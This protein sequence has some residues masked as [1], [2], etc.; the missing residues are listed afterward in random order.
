MVGLR[1]KLWLSFI[2]LCLAVM[3][4][5]QASVL[6]NHNDNG[7]TG[8]NLNE[9]SLTTSNVGPTTFGRLFA[10]S[11]DGQIYAQ[12]LI[13][14]GLSIRGKT[15]NVVYVATMNDS[16]YAFDADD[17]TASSPLWHD[18]FTNPPNVVPVPYQDLTGA[19][20]I[21]PI[22]GILSTPVI[23]P[24]TNTIFVVT[25]SLEGDPNVDSSYVQRLHAIDLVTGAERQKS[26]VVLGASVPGTGD[27]GT[28][29]VYDGRIQNQRPGLLL[30][31]GIVY[32]ASASHG[33]N[34]SYH[35][36]VLGYDE[37]SLTLK[38]AHVTTPNGYR[39][40]IW[41]S[42][43]GLTADAN[44]YIYFMT[45]NGL[46]DADP[47]LTNGIDYGDTFEKLD[48]NNNLA[49]VDFF[50]PH[51]QGDLDSSDA[52]LGASGPMLIP[53]SHCIIGGGK[54]GLLYLVNTDDM[55]HFSS[56]GTDNVQQE[57][58]G[59]AG[60]LHGTTA[61]WNGP[62]GPTLYVWGEGDACYAWPWNSATNMVNTSSPLQ[63]KDAQGNVIVPAGG[64]PGGI[65]SISANGSK[66]G[67]GILW[68][69]ANFDGDANQTTV[70]GILHAFDATTMKELW[71]SKMNA[72]DD[73]GYFAK[74]CPPTVANGKVYM[75]TFGNQ[76]FVYSLIPAVVPGQVGTVK[77]TPF[78]DTVNLYWGAAPRASSY[79]IQRA[80]GNG[81]FTQY[82]TVATTAFTD[83]RVYAGTTYSYRIAGVN[84]TGTG[85]FSHTFLVTPSFPPTQLLSN[86]NGYTRSGAN[87]LTNY[88]GSTTVSTGQNLPD[89][90]RQTYVSFNIA[91]IYTTITSAQLWLYGAHNMSGGSGSDSVYAVSPNWSEGALTFS[92]QPTLG[93]KLATQTVGSTPGYVKWDVTQYVQQQRWYKNPVVSFGIAMDSQPADLGFD[94]FNSR[95]NA[96]NKPILV[97]T[98]GPPPI[99]FPGGFY[100]TPPVTLNGSASFNHQRLQ[101]TDG[102]TSEAGSAWANKLVNVQSFH[103]AFTF[104]VLNPNADGFAFCLQN[105]GPN[106]LGPLGGDLGYTGLAQSVCIK[107]DLYDNAGE[108][109]NSTGLYVNGAAPQVPAIDLTPSGIDLHSGRVMNVTLSETPQ[110]GLV[111]TIVD[112]QTGARF[113]HVFNV[114]VASVIGS[115][116]A[117]AGFTGGTGGLTCTTQIIGWVYGP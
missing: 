50:T 53:G 113:V 75:A 49:V 15:R 60:E 64:S 28:S 93:K 44:G 46:F 104:Q 103:T 37:T 45:G 79:V 51:N 8:Q 33:D 57:F 18:S 38:S 117:Y 106:A 55:L 14:A 95:F 81:S 112:P 85:P 31:N 102:G 76:L 1:L 107:F 96:S 12:P 83:N 2:G 77:G 98:L 88:A 92:S 62:N 43:Q 22:V 68:A 71:N 23:D 41:Q 111:L 10:R 27:G 59:S 116:T 29:I 91:P 24:G 39:G 58:Q 34:G 97:L 100:Q 13:V 99:Y 20:D 94:V 89:D 109:T 87:A 65:L 6:T 4:M 73:Y 9:T 48:S 84:K 70:H 61:Y 67:T 3:A 90:V 7:R 114:N 40:G 101:I 80:I 69:N 56:G 78:L 5:G 30:L 17:P 86:A 11:V 16:L 82:A 25:K 74:F 26:P 105:D 54:Q 52:D 72:Y 115:S 32:I 36:W 21:H 110:S 19:G 66:S 63:G 35:G 108:G 42:G 47:S